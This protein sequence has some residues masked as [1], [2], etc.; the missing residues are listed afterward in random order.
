MF[1]NLEV[2]MAACL[3][4]GISKGEQVRKNKGNREQAEERGRKGVRH[5]R[6]A[7]ARL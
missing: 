7:S 4:Q 1:Y 3:M 2:S 6:R 5:G